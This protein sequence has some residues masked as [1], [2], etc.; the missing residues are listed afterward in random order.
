MTLA[1]ELFTRI[2]DPGLARDERVLLQCRLA[3]ELE[4]AGSYEAAREALGDLWKGVG[5]RPVTTNIRRGTCAE[6]LLRTGVLSGWLGSCKQIEGSVEGAKDLIG[7]SIQIFNDLEASERAAEAQMELGYCYWREGAFNEARDLLVEALGRLSITNSEVRAITMLRIALVEKVS[8]R[9]NDALRLH[10]EAAPL[11]AASSN[12]SIK[13]R[14]HNEYGTVLKNLGRA[15]GRKDYV[16]R[17]L[18][19]YAASSYHFEQAGH[20]RYQ[21]Y[22][23]NN[24]GFLYGII[25]RF[26]DAHEHLDR[27]QALFTSLKDKAHIAQ[28]D[29]TRARVLLEEGRATEAARFANA[30]VQALDG[31]DQQALLAEALTT[32]GIGLARLGLHKNSGVALQRAVEV[33]QV[34][35]DL[36]DAGL[37]ELSIIEELG[38]HLTLDELSVKYDRALDLLSG[39][40]N[41]ATK[42]RLLTC[43]QRVLYLSGII[44]TPPSWEN[45][46]LKDALRR[47][48]ARIIE[49]ALKES[50]RSVTRAARM[51]GFR[52]HT[53]LIKK[54]NT[55]HE[56]LLTERAPIRQRR[57][58]LMFLDASAETKSQPVAILHVEDNL[59]VAD[60][61]KA[62]LELEGWIVETVSDGATAAQLLESDV[63]FDAIILDNDLPGI[64]G[65]ELINHLRCLAHRQNIPL[66][67]LTAGDIEKEARQQ[68]VN[69]F[70]KKPDEVMAVTETIARLLAR[71][72]KA[73]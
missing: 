36:E 53:S 55:W 18:I 58:S 61:V 44:P 26:G 39:S 71:K 29:D 64:T 19:E 46:H 1:N 34:A 59:L 17:A 52:N 65:L 22:V 56:N 35:G 40:R 38:P 72:L 45:F 32:L 9:L 15:E 25:R 3:K 67:M 6:V 33:A 60:A 63:P 13:G 73:K 37:A 47:Y 10:M 68:G 12:D 4:E 5:Q 16:D 42:E 50:G 70:L 69:A 28:V 7:E 48:E 23:E 14:F 2:S 43:A 66:I 57:Q 21:A 11:F 27:A 8:N 41:P 24:L 51:L 30:A 54:L 49:R 31:G 62:A 20:S